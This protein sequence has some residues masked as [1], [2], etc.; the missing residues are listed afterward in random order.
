M[1]ETTESA[2]TAPTQTTLYLVNNAG[3]FE[4]STVGPAAAYLV[5]NAVIDAY[6]IDTAGAAH[7]ASFF[8]IGTT[9]YIR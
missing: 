6:E 8:M 3:T 9:A 2:D 7:D 5:Y 1:G 4:V